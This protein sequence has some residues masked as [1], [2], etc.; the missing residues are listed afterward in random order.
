MNFIVSGKNI[1]VTDALR[2]RV[3]SKLGKL[4][5]FFSNDAEIHTTLS[6]QKNRQIV[7][8]TIPFKGVIF[9]S[10]QSNEDMYNAIDKVVDVLE[11]Q[12]IKNKTKLQHK[13]KGDS[14]RFES[15]KDNKEDV[16][17]EENFKIVKSK[18]FEAKPMTSEE[19]IMQMDLVG[20]EF[21]IFR[22][23]DNQ[24]IN[25]IYKRKDG[26]LGLIEPEV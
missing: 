16:L 6:V 5:K 1:D 23:A 10:E 8:V 25:V 11:R 3:E 14:L 24:K 13:F 18:K 21:Y 17:N 2:D 9:R 7:E 4:S 20:H 19:A 12:I 22:N 26:N 15:L